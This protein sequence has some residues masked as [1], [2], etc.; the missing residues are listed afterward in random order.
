MSMKGVGFKLNNKSKM[1]NKTPIGE[2]HRDVFD[3]V[4]LTIVHSAI[5]SIW[6]RSWLLEAQSVRG[7]DIPGGGEMWIKN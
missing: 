7:Y 1:K 3:T 5:F 4:V 2:C 6:T